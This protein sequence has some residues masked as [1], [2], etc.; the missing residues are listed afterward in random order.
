MY[1]FFFF[2]FSTTLCN[3]DSEKWIRAVHS[4]G[5]FQGRD[6]ILEIPKVKIGWS[7]EIE[8][9]VTRKN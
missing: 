8:D 4:N 6:V 7:R 1:F 5:S 9:F 3:F 2:T